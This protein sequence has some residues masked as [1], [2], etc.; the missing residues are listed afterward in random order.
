MAKLYID[1]N[2]DLRIKAKK[3]FEKDFFRLM[4][5]AV[6]GKTMEI[7]RKHRDMKFVTADRRRKYLVTEST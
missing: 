2:T 5:I 4:N 3:S 7:V 1:M 6:F